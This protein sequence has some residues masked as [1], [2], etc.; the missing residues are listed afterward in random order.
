MHRQTKLD[1][2]V[3]DLLASFCRLRIEKDVRRL[4]G[5]EREGLTC[6]VVGW[7]YLDLNQR[8]P[9][10]SGALPALPDVLVSP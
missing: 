4:R 8:P 6:V 10:L 5:D 1:S 3:T 2:R 7:A 9:F